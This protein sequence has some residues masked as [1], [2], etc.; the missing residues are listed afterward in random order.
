MTTTLY[1]LT[2][3]FMMNATYIDPS[4]D[5][6]NAANKVNDWVMISDNV[7]GGI[8]KSKLEYTETS[9][10]L[11][12]TISLANYGGFSS[13]KT[14]FKNID[15]SEYKG[16]KIRYRSANQRYAITL[17]D[18]RNWTQP[19]FK[20]DLPGSKSDVWSE[21][22][23]YFKDFKEYQIGEPTGGKLDPNSLKDIVRLGIIT[24]EKKE[25]P[26]SLEIDYVEFIK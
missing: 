25:G 11:T 21:A 12:G 3:L 9:L 5:F 23:I 26:F 8:T 18:S 17:E 10:V 20:G 1:I 19:N 7:M 16:L 14:R 6:G 13:V 15:L 24:T 4:I 2:A 22:T